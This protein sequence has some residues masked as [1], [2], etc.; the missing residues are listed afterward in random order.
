MRP[1]DGV[2]EPLED[3]RWE[4]GDAAAGRLVDGRCDMEDGWLPSIFDLL[5]SIS[6]SA[7]AL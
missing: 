5:S 4:L 1:E 7:S 2:A 3:R 6:H